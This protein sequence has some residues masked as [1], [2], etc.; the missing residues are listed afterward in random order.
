MTDIAKIA[1]EA[2]TSSLT[3]GTTALKN[4][5]LVGNQTAKSVMRNT[6]G[7]AEGFDNVRA[8]IKNFGKN[9][10]AVN[11]K[12]KAFGH[13]ARQMSMQLSQVAQQGSVTGN[14]L[15]ALAIQLPDLALGFGT[16]GILIGAAAGALA[17][18]FINAAKKASKASDELKK[19]IDKLIT[20]FDDLGHA[21]RTLLT[22]QIAE[23]T[24]TLSKENRLL[25][26][27]T[28]NLITRYDS[29]SRAYERGSIGIVE[30]NKKQKDIN[31][32]L[33]EN[34]AK[35]EENNKTMTDRNKILTESVKKEKAVVDA[36][37][38]VE[39]ARNSIEDRAGDRESSQQAQQ[40]SLTASL[41]TQTQIIFDTA[42]REKA[43][44]ASSYG[45]NLVDL[46]EYR[47]QRQL[48]DEKFSEASI[49]ITRR[50]EAQKRQLLSAGTAAG[51]SILGGQLGQMAALFKEGGQK[52]FDE[53]KTFATG[54][55][56]ISAALAA[57]NALAVPIIGP[58][59]SVTAAALGAAQVAIIQNQTYQ[60]TRAMGGQVS[61]GGRFLV[62]EN[63]PEVLQ[64][65][66]QGGSITPNH[67][68]DSGGGT[69]VTT[70]VNIQA[71]VTKGEVVSL[72][73]AITQATLN[74]VKAEIARGGTMAKAV[75]ARK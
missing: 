65:G 64:L 70:I 19:Q 8:P 39:E 2:D 41:R 30:Y 72:I 5:Q 59:L 57:N 40:D 48:I 50:E 17:V 43:I 32:T 67:A 12:V 46:N 15:Q 66:G 11:P 38:L 61:A 37:K 26:S 6:N 28:K 45:S 68:L 49:E 33:I 25:A 36:L 62:G 58:A 74:A 4:F 31:Q 10:A 53:Y 29:L 9:I 52:T 7:M 22:L 14:F 1:I 24:K 34:K 35:I 73:P 69:N 42:A 56:I 44:L 71:G 63:G 75:G 13:Q 47:R 23:E 60:G 18:F 27:D 55:A 3:K 51:I 54:Q 20:S 21:Q 16:L